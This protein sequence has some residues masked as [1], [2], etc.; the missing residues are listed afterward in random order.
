MGTGDSSVETLG[1]KPATLAELEEIIGYT[2]QLIAG[3]R[4][5]NPRTGVRVHL[6]YGQT[7][8]NL[9]IYVAASSPRI[10][11]LAART[12]D[13]AFVLVGTDPR[14]L[15]ASRRALDAGAAESR[16]DL[17][18]VGFRVVCWTPCSIQEDGAA[19]R[20]AVKA[21]VARILK[22]RLPFELDEE[23]MNVVRNIREQY[24]YDEHMVPGTAH[25]ELVPDAL[26]EQFALAGTPAEVHRQLERLASTGLVDEIAIVPHTQQP[27]QRERVI[28]IVGQFIASLREAEVGA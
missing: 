10:H 19:A 7:G 20:A 12:A 25:G 13:G 22:R 27:D 1:R 26:V 8:V 15:A 18:A 4:A 14:Y 3:E 2:R 9:P 5:L 11:A 17:N 24:V 23:T 28:D 21:H 16:R 6:S